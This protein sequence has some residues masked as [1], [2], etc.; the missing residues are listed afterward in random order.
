MKVAFTEDGASKLSRYES[1]S[2][3]SEKLEAVEVVASMETLLAA[4]ADA[5][6]AVERVSQVAESSVNVFENHVELYTTDE[7]ALQEALTGASESLSTH[8]VL[9]QVD[10]LSSLDHGTEI[11]GGQSMRDCTSGFS[12]VHDDGTRGITTAAHCAN[13]NQYVGSV[14]LSRPLGEANIGPRDVQWHVVKDDEEDE[15]DEGD[16]YTFRNLVYDGSHHR[17]I[18]STKS[19]SQQSIG[20][21]VCKFGMTTHRTCGNI[22]AKNFLHAAPYNANFWIRVHKEGVDLS[23]GGDS[24]GPWFSGNVAYGIH[25]GNAHP[26]DNDATYMAIDFIESLDINVLTTSD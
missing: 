1:S 13:I 20:E 26:D 18:Y 12:V 11:H 4:Q 16:G 19:R 17:Y 10:Q 25:H 5:I 9:I 15:G 14:A 7:Q 24:G 8:V 2:D 3:L 23:Q 6:A 21:Y 22:V